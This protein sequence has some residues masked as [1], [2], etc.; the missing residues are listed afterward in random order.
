MCSREI[1]A[2]VGGLQLG[3]SPG[4]RDPSATRKADSSH[5]HEGGLDGFV[6]LC[7]PEVIAVGAGAGGGGLTMIAGR[8]GED[9]GTDAM[10]A[11]T[12]NLGRAALQF[13]ELTLE[14]GH[15]VKAAMDGDF[16][17]GGVG[18]FEESANAG[19][20]QFIEIGGECL[21]QVGS[22]VAAEG[23]GAHADVFGDVFEIQGFADA[24]FDEAGD[25]AE[26]TVID[27]WGF[28][29]K[30]GG[31]DLAE[32]VAGAQFVEDFQQQDETLQALGFEKK[33]HTLGHAFAGGAAHL[34]AVG[35]L[36][37][38]VLQL[39]DVGHLQPAAKEAGVE[40]DGDGFD[41]FAGLALG[42]FVAVAVQ[43]VGTDHH[44]VAGSER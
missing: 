22:Q 27:R 26:A 43:E 41:G 19:D 18:F 4:D 2:G 40:L 11:L 37:E 9:R 28:Q 44:E 34:D 5:C 35:S 20:A 6:G 3:F 39:H 15:G 13:A 38:E 17:D 12:V 31:G 16:A 32:I 24:L 33:R 21:A 42:V 30:T 8:R 7:L 36:T 25:A 23:D 10:G 1:T 29:G 14:V